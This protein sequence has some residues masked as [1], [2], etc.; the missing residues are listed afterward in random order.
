MSECGTQSGI[1][2]MLNQRDFLPFTSHLS[3]S[4]KSVRVLTL[5]TLDTGHVLVP[6][7]G[8]DNKMVGT[9]SVIK[10]FRNSSSLHF[11][12]IL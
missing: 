4:V 7:P 3:Q 6:G 5:Q 10:Q 1:L 8:S 9:A 12:T 2:G 11:L